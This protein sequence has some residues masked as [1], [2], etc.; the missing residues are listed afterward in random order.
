MVDWNSEAELVRDAAAFKNLLHVLLGLYIWEVGLSLDFDLQFILRRRKFLWPMAFYFIGR[1]SM[2]LALIGVVIGLNVTSEIN[3][4]GLFIFSQLFGNIAIAMSAI[5]LSVRTMAIWGR[6]RHIVIPLTLALIGFA[7]VL[8]RGIIGVRDI[9]VPASGCTIVSSQQTILRTIYI[10]GMSLDMIVLLLTLYRLGFGK[11]RSPLMKLLLADGLVYFIIT[12]TSNMIA[13]IFMMLNLNAVM[14]VIADVPAVVI[15][16]IASCRAVRRLMNHAWESRRS[17]DM[18]TP[19]NNTNTMVFDRRRFTRTNVTTG[20]EQEVHTQM[21]N[22]SHTQTTSAGA[23]SEP[24]AND[25]FRDLEAQTD[26][27]P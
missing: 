20:K 15:C 21:D 8:L 3:C 9:W 24:G 19:A 16:T 12:F 23:K 14:A 10:Y 22:Y 18:F 7:G 2:L 13:V 5:N 1:Y 27:D 17:N 11:E 6:A 4:Q 26:C 25:S